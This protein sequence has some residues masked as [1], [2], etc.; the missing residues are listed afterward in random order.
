LVSQGLEKEIKNEKCN[1]NKDSKRG[2]YEIIFDKEHK[3]KKEKCKNAGNRK[4]RK[5]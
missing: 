3:V 2:K 4:G 1:K 5:K